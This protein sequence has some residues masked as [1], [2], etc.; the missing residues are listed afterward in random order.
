MRRL[1]RSPDNERGATG[2]LVAV[3]MLVLMGAGA[4]AVDVG[5]IYAERAQLQN[6]ADAGAMAVARRCQKAGGCTVPQAMAWATELS[7]PNANDGATTVDSVDLSVPHQVTVVTS[8]LNGTS[9][10]GFLTKMFASALNA[11]PVTVRAGAIA[12]WQDTTAA[13]AFPLVFD[14][15]QI[16]PAYAPLATTVLIKE[17]GKSPCVG[18][19]S[20]H[21]IPGGFGWL[22]EAGVCDIGAGA[23]GWV[24]SNTGNSKLPADCAATLDAW[25]TA[26]DHSKKRYATAFFPIFDDGDKGGKDGRFHLS[27]FARVE[28]HGWSFVKDV[29]GLSAPKA[30]P[31]CAALFKTG[32]DLGICGQFQEFIPWADRGSER[33]PYYLNSVVKLI[34]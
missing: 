12:I 9:G 30:D 20:G 28:I 3:M 4:M 5:Q 19:P 23:D 29:D 17:H 18:S 24:G 16:T 15:C 22:A 33:G 14:Q 31:A 26:I 25:R 21:H 2:V 13:G 27:G 11:P 34:K 1:M 10:A 8:T 32:S 6:G 7:G